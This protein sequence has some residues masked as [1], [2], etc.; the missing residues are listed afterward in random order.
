VFQ[1]VVVGARRLVA[2]GG[3]AGAIE[4][5]RQVVR[6]LPPSLPAAIA[7]VL[8]TGSGNPA[9]A[10]RSAANL[11]VFA[12]TDGAERL[13]GRM[14]DALPRAAIA[15]A[16]ADRCCL[17]R[18][19]ARRSPTGR[20]GYGPETLDRAQSDGLEGA[21]WTAVRVLRERLALDRRMSRLSGDRGLDGL[22]E[23]YA[24]RA[25]RGAEQASQV[26]ALLREVPPDA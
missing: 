5:M 15:A 7:V 12:R 22:A 11:P 18:R 26:E 17:R 24:S 3:S 13:P 14:F 25:A 4:A 19:S 8:H 1:H 20:P 10:I 2:I 9:G 21:L 23:R 16:V 6:A